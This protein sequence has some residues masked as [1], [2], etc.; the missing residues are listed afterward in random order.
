MKHTIKELEEAL[1]EYNGGLYPH[2]DNT[3]A[4]ARFVSNETV[5]TIR[6]TL[7]QALAIAK[8]DSV[9]VP[10]GVAQGGGE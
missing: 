1:Q 2:I 3:F 10:R 8:G 9:V 6:D 4:Q 7:T 5:Y